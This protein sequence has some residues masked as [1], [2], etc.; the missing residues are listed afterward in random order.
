MDDFRVG[1]ETEGGM[2]KDMLD[3]IGG[4]GVIL[5]LVGLIVGVGPYVWQLWLTAG[6]PARTFMVGLV[7]FLVAIVFNKEL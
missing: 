5:V 2:N 7:M 4:L 6:W 1:N 3:V